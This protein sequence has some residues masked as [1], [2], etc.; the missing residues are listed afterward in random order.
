[1]PVYFDAHLRNGLE[2]KSYLDFIDF[3]ITGRMHFGISGIAAGKPMFGI[4]YANKFEGMLRLFEIDPDRNLIDYTVL[5][6]CVK[7]VPLFLHDLDENRL[8]IETFLPRV[9][10]Q[11]FLNRI[12]V[13]Q[14]QLG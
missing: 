3:T 1:M 9:K 5:A 10:K 7:V 2:L 8:K 14:Y 12:S 4:C 6:D 13:A 11:S